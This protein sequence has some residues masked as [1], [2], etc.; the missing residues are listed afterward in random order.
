MGDDGDDE[1]ND[2]AAA[3]GENKSSTSLSDDTASQSVDGLISLPAFY[4]LISLSFAHSFYVNL[5][6]W[7]LLQICTIGC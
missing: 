4:P 6:R 3:D 2:D 7:L 5:M 1:K